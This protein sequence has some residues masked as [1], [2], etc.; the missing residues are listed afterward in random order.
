MLGK[1]LLKSLRLVNVL[2]EE[3]ISRTTN[4]M[5]RNIL[6]YYKDIRALLEGPR[7]I[8]INNK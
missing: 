1:H 6:F 7:A 5:P 8:N 3:L 4:L 2:A